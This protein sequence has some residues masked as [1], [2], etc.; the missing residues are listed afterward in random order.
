MSVTDQPDRSGLECAHGHPAGIVGVILPEDARSAVAHYA[1]CAVCRTRSYIG[2]GL[3]TGMRIVTA[4]DRAAAREAQKDFLETYR[5]I[6]PSKP[7]NGEMR[8][9]SA[10]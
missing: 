1:A 10:R 9:G 8:S 3:C 5:E 7:R 6:N 4:G 2:P